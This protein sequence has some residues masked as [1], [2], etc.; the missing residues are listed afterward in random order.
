MRPLELLVVN[1][2]DR[3]NPQAGG[4]EV[5]LHEVFGRL[6][7][8]GHRVT[9][10]ASGWAGA[11]PHDRVD[12]L[13]VVRVGGRRSFAL[14]APGAL[15]RRLRGSAVDVVVEDVNKVPLLVPAW[16]ARPCLAL[17]HH[18]FGPSAL[19]A[20][21]A[22]A[23]GATWALERALLPR[24]RGTLVQ[25]VS[26]STARELLALGLRPAD[27]H[28]VRN[29][30]DAAWFGAADVPRAPVPT[31]A[32]V[33][34]LVRPKRV[35]LALAALARL[36]RRLPQARLVVVGDGP[37][38]PRLR[39]HAERLG[40]AAAVE[41]RGR[42]GEA[43]KRRVYH[44]AWVHVAV[45]RKEGW[46]LT[47]M[48]AAACGTPTVAADVP[49]LRESVVHEQTGLLVPSGDVAALADALAALLADPGR[50]AALGAAARA[51]AGR[52]SWDAA[53]DATEALLHVALERG[54]RGRDDDAA[55]LRRDPRCRVALPRLGAGR[56]PYGATRH[57]VCVH[58]VA[59]DATLGAADA[60]GR[61][62][63]VVFHAPPPAARARLL[64][65]RL[66]DVEA[67]A[68]DGDVVWRLTGW[69]ADPAAWLAW[70]LDAL[71][72]AGAEREGVRRCG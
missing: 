58:G 71:P 55:L 60:G 19:A 5:H 15:R 16:A 57:R 10:L 45:S 29:G 69:P 21:G 22:L 31:V 20:A 53:A 17:V 52:H 2:M 41:F 27:V 11:P 51:H 42:V 35:E 33:G 44:E 64:G 46:G 59:C 48:E 50:R 54:V 61:W 8:R 40:I 25:A 32:C 56:N 63:S 62:P 36:R 14:R 24:Y 37:E 65:V 1:W 12:G 38:L 68:E 70:R 72:A 4:A 13:E 34:R 3:A 23:G 18:L 47:V 6:A 28:V 39:R 7:R 26:D 49:G 9:L 30:V 67:R 66:P 43:E